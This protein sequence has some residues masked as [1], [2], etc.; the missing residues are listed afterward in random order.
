MNGSKMPYG[1]IKESTIGENKKT[2]EN[3]QDGSFLSASGRL[4]TPTMKQRMFVKRAVELLDPTKAAQEVFATTDP[5]N[6]R[7]IA[8]T[9][10]K[11]K[12]VQLLLKKFIPDE[13]VLQTV[14]DQLFA[15]TPKGK[16]E[17]LYPDNMA[18][19]KAADIALKLK[20]AYP[21]DA[22][23]L[24]VAGGSQINFIVT[25]MAPEEEVIIG[26]EVVDDSTTK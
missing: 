6:A 15:E 18:R 16:D 26:E 17:N 19:L 1:K 10:M 11:R 14:K 20:G 7:A 23:K 4:R 9:T 22:V 24:N 5:A 25:K 21:T 8:S 13:M 12:G 3:A 2:V